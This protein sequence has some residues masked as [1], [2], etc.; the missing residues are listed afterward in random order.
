VF[1]DHPLVSV[2]I[3]LDAILGTI[4]L[5]KELTDN[6]VAAFGRRVDTPIGEKFHCLPN[7]VFVF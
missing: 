6:F 3:V 1:A 2:N 4:T 7:T 5:S